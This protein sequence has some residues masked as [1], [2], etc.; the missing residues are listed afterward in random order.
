MSC[1][2]RLPVYALFAAAFFPSSGQN[3]VFALYLI[4]IA[5]AILTGMLMKKTLLPGISSGFMMEL[6]PYHLPTIKGVLLR[7]WDRVRVFV[8]EAGQVI[9]IMVLALN[10][11]NSIGTDGSFGNRDSEQS[12]LSAASR[13]LV[14][15]FA[16]M[17][18]Q[19]DNWPAVVKE[20]LNG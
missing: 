9:I 20:W 12:I 14:P 1:G 16:P 11:L 13:A 8:K 7:A 15:A 10:L 19:E 2:A 4:G 3:V 5:V 18:L 6:P 17:G